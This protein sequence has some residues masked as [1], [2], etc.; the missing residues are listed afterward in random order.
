MLLDPA[1]SLLFVSRLGCSIFSYLD[2]SSLLSSSICVDNSSC[3][4]QTHDVAH[5]YLFKAKYSA[6]IMDTVFPAH[7][8]LAFV[9]LDRLH[10]Y[11]FPVYFAAADHFFLSFLVPT[12]LGSRTVVFEIHRHRYLPN[13][14]TFI[15]DYGD[16]IR[17]LNGS[18]ADSTVSSNRVEIKKLFEIS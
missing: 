2:L 15:S 8:I 3:A 5:F 1:N 14:T 11:F 13:E 7:G 18:L 10:F 17:R 16:D 6:N 4:M 12:V 9:F